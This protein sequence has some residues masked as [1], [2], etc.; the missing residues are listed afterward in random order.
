MLSSDFLRDDVAGV[1]VDAK[2]EDRRVTRDSSAASM[3]RRD[4]LSLI[5]AAAGSAAMYHAMTSLGLAAESATKARSSSAAIPKAL[6]AD[7]RRGPCRHDRGARAAQGRLQ[8]PGP[9]I[10]RPRGRAQLDPAR[11]RPLYRAGRVRPELRIRPGPLHQSRAVAHPVP[12]PRPARLLQAPQVSRSSRS[13]R[14][15]TTPICIRQDAFGGKP[16][17][18]PPRP[19]RLSAAAS[20]SCS[21][22]PPRRASSTTP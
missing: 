17:R 8:G 19:G 18:Y 21:P 16:Q 1:W 10:Q 22:R 14:S 20:P 9:R 12:P 11:R 7:P 3:S 5:G 15:T 2:A 13:S 6:G 4:L